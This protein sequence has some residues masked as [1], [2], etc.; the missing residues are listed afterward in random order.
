MYSVSVCVCVSVPLG[1]GG[2][3][4]FNVHMPFLGPHS[5]QR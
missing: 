1:G 5:D 3:F 4:M 2:N